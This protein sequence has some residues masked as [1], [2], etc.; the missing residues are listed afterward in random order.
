MQ[1]S[2]ALRA[3]WLSYNDKTYER[4]L[5]LKTGY[6]KNRRVDLQSY[7]KYQSTLLSLLSA[8]ATISLIPCNSFL[9]SS[10]SR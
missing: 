4:H 1:A 2:K 5:D 6:E 3:S 7:P 8:D 9:V 10:L